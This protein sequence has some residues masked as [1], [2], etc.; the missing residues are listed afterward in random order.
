MFSFLKNQKTAYICF[1]R[2]HKKPFY[3]ATENGES[4]DW[5]RRKLP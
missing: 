5:I 4:G 3:F 1:K 2:K